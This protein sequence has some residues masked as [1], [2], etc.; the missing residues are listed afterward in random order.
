M[1]VWFVTMFTEKMEPE[2]IKHWIDAGIDMIED[3]VK[4]SPSTLDD[5]VVLPLCNLVRKAL[6]IPDYEDEPKKEEK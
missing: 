3:K 6:S 5:A 2:E 1:I 4:E